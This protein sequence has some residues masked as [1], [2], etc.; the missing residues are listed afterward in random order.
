[1][2]PE[3]LHGKKISI[4]GAERSGIAAALLLARSGADVFV[5]DAAP[6]EK[7]RENVSVLAE[8]G[9]AFESGAHSDR[10]YEAALIVVSPGVP[11]T[12]PVVVEAR[13]RQIPVVG[14]LEAASW[15]CHSPIIAVTG[16]NGKTTT[17]TL[18]DR[19]LFDAKK[20]HATGGNIGTAFSAVVETVS[21]PAPVLL[22]VSSFQLDTIERFR[23]N[24]AIVLNITQNHLNRYEYVMEKYARAKARIAENQTAEDVLIWNLDDEWSNKLL[25]SSPARQLQI[26]VRSR[27]NEGAYLE[28]GILV[29]RLAGKSVP[30]IARDEISI[31][32]EHNLYNAMAAVLAAQLLGV[33]TASIRATLRNFKG[34]E[35]RQEFVREVDGVTYI[36]NSKATTVEAVAAAL[37]SY[38]QPIVLILG[39][40]DKGNDYSTIYDLVKEHVRAIVATGASAETIVNNFSDKVQVERVNTIG[41]SMPNRVS[42]EKAVAVAASLAREGDIVLLAPACTSFDWFKDYEERGRVFKSVVNLL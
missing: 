16:S 7:I 9:I 12:A 24:V 41:A 25:P 29:S 4:L 3:E 8:Q 37:K 10:V 23:P 20:E 35:H 6:L 2:R 22:E 30:V 32:G 11:S 26:S 1:M 15:F 40:M 42:M 33:D 27:V 19:M 5:S 14:E 21:A 18:L 28:E 34:V 17:T 31:K 13:K 39:G 36:N 38:T